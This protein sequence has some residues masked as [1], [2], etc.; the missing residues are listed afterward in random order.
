LFTISGYLISG[1]GK[2]YKRLLYDTA[3]QSKEKFDRVVYD[4]FL[5]N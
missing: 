2:G 1:M 5:S 3:L 4:S